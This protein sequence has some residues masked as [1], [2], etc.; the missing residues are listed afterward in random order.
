MKDSLIGI[1]ERY[2]ASK[3][4]ALTYAKWYK[5]RGYSARY[6]KTPDINFKKKGYPHMVTILHYG[7][8]K[9]TKCKRCKQDWDRR[10]SISTK[11]NWH[12]WD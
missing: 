5:S 7:H 11:G 9:P 3:K 1:Q 8:L 10:V 4:K 2:F 12:Y 6:M